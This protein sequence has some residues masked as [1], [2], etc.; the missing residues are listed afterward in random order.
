MPK[1]IYAF[2]PTINKRVVHKVKKG[3]AVS[4]VSGNKFKYRRKKKI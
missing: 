1:Y 3:Y 4:M 2:D